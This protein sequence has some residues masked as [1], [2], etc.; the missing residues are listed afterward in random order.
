MGWTDVHAQRLP[1][2]GIQGIQ[3]EQVVERLGCVAGID[4]F[5]VFRPS[6]SV[7]Q[8]AAHIGKPPGRTAQGRHE[9]DLPLPLFA[10]NESQLLSIR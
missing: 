2:G 5:A 9:V 10:A 4:D 3:P 8:A 6:G 7:A 1:A